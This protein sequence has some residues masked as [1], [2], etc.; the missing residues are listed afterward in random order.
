MNDASCFFGINSFQSA[1]EMLTFAM[2]TEDIQQ[3]QQVQGF[4]YR[5][6]FVQTAVEKCTNF[7]AFINPR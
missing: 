3:K 1:F 5:S 7:E 6:T 2:W 4:L